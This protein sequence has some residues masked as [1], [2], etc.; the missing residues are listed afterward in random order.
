MVIDPMILFS[1]LVVLLQRHDS[2]RSFFAYE[3][4]VVPMSLFKEN[5]MRKPS[6]S[7]LAKGLHQRKAKRASLVDPNLSAEGEGEFEE[8]EEE[9]TSD[10]EDNI[11]EILENFG[12]N[13]TYYTQFGTQQ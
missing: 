10:V 12:I 9:N 4:S 13:T 11:F 2:I 7:V 5:I 6:K 1:R 3:L 8:D